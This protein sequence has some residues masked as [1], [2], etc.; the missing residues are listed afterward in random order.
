MI[1]LGE[2]S[3]RQILDEDLAHSTLPANILLDRNNDEIEVP[4][5]PRYNM[6]CRMEIFRSRAA[7][8]YLDI[9]RT[10]CQNRCRIRRT[11]C[12]TIADWDNLQLDAE[13]LDQ[14]LRAF[15]KEEATVDFSV[16]DDPIYA[17]PLSS[18]AYYYKLRQME[19]II[20]MGFELETYQPYELASMYWYLQY[21]AK[22]RVRHLERIRGF[23]A[24]K[25]TALINDSSIK[26]LPAKSQLELQKAREF[27]NFWTL[28]AT[29]TISLSDALSS[30]FAV[31][32]RLNLL[33]TPSRPYSDDKM[34]YEVR[35][36]PFSP[37]GL[38]E[39]IPFSELTAMV[40][41]PDESIPDLLKFATVSAASAKRAFEIMSKMSPEE[42]FCQGSHDSW[43]KNIKDCL[44][45]SIFT[46]ISIAAVIKAVQTAGKIIIEIPPPGKGYHDWWI[47]PKVIPV[48]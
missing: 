42:A 16:A 13:E 7:S 40:T 19:W 28:D 37:I 46:N 26:E 25:L 36:K 4:T 34:R 11:L 6:A 10:I 3:I 41:Q 45:A 47:V 14:E 29:A 22:T 12:H 39:M 1:V 38:P 2:M 48:A 21:L 5:D 30:L 35:M 44:K 33:S 24:R 32:E 23:N 15:T 17:F 31:L 20:Q 18:W 9:L 27:D 8:S 43:L